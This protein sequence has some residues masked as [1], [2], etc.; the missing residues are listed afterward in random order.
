MYLHTPLANT[1][2]MS[3]AAGDGSAQAAAFIAAMTTPPSGARNTLITNCIKGLWADG[4]FQLGDALYLLAAADSQAASIN[5]ITPG[6]FNLTAVNSPTFTA[7]QGFAGGNTKYLNTNFNPFTATSPKYQRDNASLGGWSLESAADS[8]AVLGAL[9]ARYQ[10]FEITPFY[11]GGTFYGGVNSTAEVSFASG[12]TDGSGFRLLSR[13][14]SSAITAYSGS[15]VLST[16][17]IGSFA[18]V[19]DTVVLLNDANGAAPYSGTVSAAWIGA[20]LNAT[21]EAALYSRLQ[22]Y[23]HGVGAV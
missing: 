18:I 13:T 15:S 19:S 5:A 23:L 21:Q 10:Q 1:A 22:T 12:V 2:L 11:S 8:G 6:T 14:S 4:V 7:D 3:G 9:G 20:G 16:V 17:S